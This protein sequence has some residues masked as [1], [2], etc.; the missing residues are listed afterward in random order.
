[1]SDN[2]VAWSGVVVGVIGTVIGITSLVG[3]TRVLQQERMKV[4]RLQHQI[5]ELHGQLEDEQA[6]VSVQIQQ[7]RDQVQ[8]EI[9]PALDLIRRMNIVDPS[10]SML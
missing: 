1:M 4:N 5:D 3:L 10:S 9:Q 6:R 2:T 8:H 7:V